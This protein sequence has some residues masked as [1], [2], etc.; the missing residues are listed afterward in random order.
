MIRTAATRPAAALARGLARAAG[1][2]KP[3]ITWKLREK[4]IFD[5]VVATLHLDGRD[6]RLRLERAC[7]DGR[8]TPIVRP[9]SAYGRVLCDMPR[10]L[11]P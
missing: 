1:V 7:A 6:A 10:A 11:R 5:N 9:W 2:E 4:P 3:R 8:A